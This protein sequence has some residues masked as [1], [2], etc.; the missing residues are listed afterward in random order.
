MRSRVAVIWA[1]LSRPVVAKLSAEG[2]EED[3]QG[4]QGG[5]GWFG[6]DHGEKA[7]SGAASIIIKPDDLAKVVDSRW[8]GA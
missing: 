4:G 8:E 2:E 5:G 1:P 6:N 7:V 3:S